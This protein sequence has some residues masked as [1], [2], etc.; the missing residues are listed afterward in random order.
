MNL[1]K[2]I[3]AAGG[4]LF[5][6][7]SLLALAGCGKGERQ[8][9][10]AQVCLRNQGDVDRFVALMREIAVANQLR[11]V[12]TSSESQEALSRTNPEQ[13]RVENRRRAVN[14]GTVG[15]RGFGFSAGN[16]GLPEY[17]VA[18]GFTAGD[19]PADA[20]KFAARTVSLVRSK[21]PVETSSGE[22][23]VTGMKSC[24]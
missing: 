9:L 2:R 15:S 12:D 24:A 17:Q 13:A 18:I 4:M 20:R 14:I 10:I 11:F 6:F 7:A 21:W 3:K 22:T 5:V 1:R 16:L 8:F 23:G 19:Q